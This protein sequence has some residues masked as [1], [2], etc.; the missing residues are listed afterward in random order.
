MQKCNFLYLTTLLE[1][2]SHNNLCCPALL[3]NV[4]ILMKFEYR[5]QDVHKFHLRCGLNICNKNN[6]TLWFS[7]IQAKN[8]EDKNVQNLFV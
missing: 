7:D 8:G 2:T 4:I 6:E 3:N 1:V 5:V